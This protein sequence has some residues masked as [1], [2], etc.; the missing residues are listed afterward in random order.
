M[1]I[2]MK[3]LIDRLSGKGSFGS[4]V[5]KIGRDKL[6]MSALIGYCIGI[7]HKSYQNQC[8]RLRDKRINYDP[9]L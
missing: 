7:A 3:D 1:D 4:K 8:E 9:K 5:K 2:I 6:F